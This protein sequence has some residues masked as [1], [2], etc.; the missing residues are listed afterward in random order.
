MNPLE[1]MKKVLATNWNLLI[2]LD[3]STCYVITALSG[4]QNLNN[5]VSLIYQ[6]FDNQKNIKAGCEIFLKRGDVFLQINNANDLKFQNFETK[7]PD[8]KENGVLNPPSIIKYLDGNQDFSY[9]NTNQFKILTDPNHP[10]TEINA[11]LNSAF[12]S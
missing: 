7:W 12:Q 10:I 11:I 8:C 2:H 5:I 1:D 6:Q 9:E 3:S 4:Y